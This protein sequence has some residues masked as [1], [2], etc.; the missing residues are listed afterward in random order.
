M[1]TLAFS[2]E[3][4]G[5]LTGL[6][7]VPLVLFWIFTKKWYYGVI[8]GVIGVA[9]K[10]TSDSEKAKTRAAEQQL[11]QRQTENWLDKNRSIFDPTPNSTP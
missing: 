6:F 3:G 1:H 8:A 7:I 5:Y 4:A 2:A 9:F 11:E 10:V